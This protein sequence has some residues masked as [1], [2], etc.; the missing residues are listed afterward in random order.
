M[1]GPALSAATLL[2]VRQQGRQLAES[3]YIQLVVVVRFLA[4]YW[5]LA[6]GIGLLRRL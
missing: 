2:G 4:S 1:S 6:L 3:A 5:A